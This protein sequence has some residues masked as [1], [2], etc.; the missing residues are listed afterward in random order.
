M[1]AAPVTE[2][3]SRASAVHQVVPDDGKSG[4]SFARVAIDGEAYFLKK[5]S[6]RRDWIMRVTHDHVHRGYR[7]WQAGIMDAA[8]PCIDHTVVAMQL[9]GDGDDAMLSVLMRD[10]GADLV[11]EGHSVVPLAQHA[12]FIE[13]LAALSAAFWGWRDDIGDLCTMAERLRFFA[14]DNIAAELLAAGVPAP[15]AAADRGWRLL[16]ERAPRLAALA[17]AVHAQ[18]DMIA[19]PL[20]E[21]PATFLH[22]DWK[23]GNLGSHAQGRTILLDWAYPGRGPACWDLCWYVALNRARL[24][25]SKEATF[26]RFRAALEHLGVDT[27]PW[28][29]AQLDL[30]VAGI[31]ATFGW[32]KALDEDAELAWWDAAVAQAVRRQGL[33]VASA[34]R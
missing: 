31:M 6:R 12:H 17:R 24:P 16:D 21:T 22:G 19:S 1:S 33:P 18:P 26:T 4:S 5:L 13:H 11:P 20:A 28:W 9:D 2:L 7:V 14:P 8:P 32:E 29:Q 23:M 34:A 3:L 25:E 15:L 10:V 30:C 27:T